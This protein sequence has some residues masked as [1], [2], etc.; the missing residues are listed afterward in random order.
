MFKFHY[1]EKQYVEKCLLALAD[2]KPPGTDNLDGK[3]LRIA[4]R[5][6]SSP[7]CHIF[8]KY[9]EHDVCLEIW[10]EAK[11]I[12]LLK[13]SRSALTGPNSRP[14]SLL[15][16]LS[17]LLEK[18]VNVQIQNYFTCNH[19]FT[20]YQHAYKNGYSTSTALAQMTND[21]LLILLIIG[22]C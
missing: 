12:P 20:S 10:K 6:I 15:P 8:N 16:V 11:V 9:L 13:D 4:A 19:L 14:I 21:W 22:F 7:V 3:L 17:T 18:M 2:D 5:Y 1:V